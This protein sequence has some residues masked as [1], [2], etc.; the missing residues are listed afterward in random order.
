MT[1]VRKWSTAAWREQASA[2]LDE[3]LGKAGIKRTGEITQPRIRPWGTV[4]NAPTN[5]GQVWLK[6][7]GPE[8]VFEVRLYELLRDVAPEWVLEPIAIDV[9]RGWVLLP[10]G[11]TALRENAGDPI[12]AMVKVLPQYGDL[13][14][15]LMPHVSGMLAAG[16]TDM[17][18]AVMPSR[19]EEAVDAVARRA[20]ADDMVAVRQIVGRREFF[21]ERCSQAAAL[22]IEASLDHNDLH[23]GNVFLTGDRARFYDWGDSV[24]SHPFA[25]MVVALGSMPDQYGISEDDP[26]I[27]RLRD[28]YLEAF[29]DLAPHKELVEQLDLACWIGIAARALVWE[30]ALVTQDEPTEWEKAPLTVLK[31]LLADHWLG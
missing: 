2:W 21:R 27:T 10:D 8:T 17:R 4:L 14:R 24:V 22:S 19:F 15:R 13:Q 23:T 28:A 1:A 16:V 12:E 29:S 7:P 6:A 3:Q 20:D 25:S 18:A 9:S 5:T 11:G 30:R 26:A 31:H